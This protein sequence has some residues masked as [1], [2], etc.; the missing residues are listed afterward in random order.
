[1]GFLFPIVPPFLATVVGLA[2]LSLQDLHPSAYFCPE[3][4]L[5]LLSSLPQLET[6]TITFQSPI[7]SRDVGMQLSHRRITTKVTLPNLR[8]LWYGGVS[9]YLEAIL[10]RMTIPRLEWLQITLFHQLH[11]FMPNVLK[12]AENLTGGFGSAE[13][14]FLD[15]CLRVLVYPDEGAEIYTFGIQISS[16]HLDWQ[17]ASAIQIFPRMRKALSA[18]EH[19]KLEFRRSYTSL[20]AN[21]EADRTEWRE[22]LGT[23]N[24]VKTLYVNDDYLGQ[25]SRALQ[26][27]DGILPLGL[28][29][30]LRKLEYYAKGGNPFATFADA[31][32]YAA[33]PV[34]LVNH[35]TIPFPYRPLIS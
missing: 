4:L 34:T 6:F 18:V 28:F 31:R 35:S 1:M 29:P 2:T 7:P 24:N 17:V 3:D 26:V 14:Q 30:K 16:V 33:L 5:Q 12:L 32:M 25:I 19:L 10:P 8:W 23:F 11:F 13:F 27:D 20:E 15:D 21:N 22:F 9:T